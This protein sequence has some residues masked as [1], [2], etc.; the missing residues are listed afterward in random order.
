MKNL[1]SIDLLSAFDSIN[2]SIAIL[3]P[4]FEKSQEIKDFEFLYINPV[5]ESL[6]GK[7]KEDILGKKVIEIFPGVKQDGILDRYCRVYQS[8]ES[9]S[10]EFHYKHEYFDNYYLQT[11]KRAGKYLLIQT[12]DISLK[13]QKEISLLE[14][15]EILRKPLSLSKT[16]YFF[17]TTSGHFWSEEMKSIFGLNKISDF[18]EFLNT[19]ENS[20]G[21]KLTEKIRANEGHH[22]FE[23]RFKSKENSKWIYCECRTEFASDCAL[24]KIEG[25]VQDI[26]NRKNLEEELGEKNKLIEKITTVYPDVIFIADLETLKPVY[27]NKSIFASLG[28]NQK[29]IVAGIELNRVLH[30][31]DFKR[32]EEFKNRISN[33]KEDEIYEDVIRF[34]DKLGNTRHFTSRCSALTRFP[35]G[36]IRQFLGTLSDVTEQ[37]KVKESL[38][39][40]NKMLMD[41]Q[42]V[43]NIG[44]WYFKTSTGEC[45]LSDQM[46]HIFGEKIRPVENFYDFLKRRIFSEDFEKLKWLMED[47]I[48][49]NGS[50]Q[51]TYRLIR[52]DGELRIV[53]IKAQAVTDKNDDYYIK[54]VCQDVTEKWFAEEKLRKNEELLA[55][56]EE[57]ASMGS[58]EWDIKLNTVIWTKN[59]YKLLG[60][61]PNSVFVEYETYLK[62]LHPE[63][64]EQTDEIIKNTLAGKD[65]FSIE[66]RII[67]KDGKIRVFLVSGRVFRNASGDPLKMTVTCIDVTQKRKIEKAAREKEIAIEA[68]KLLSQKKNEFISIASHE[69]KTP[70]TSLKA[71]LQLLDRLITD[72]RETE[73]NYIQKT[74]NYIQKLENLIG[75]LLDISKIESGRI[76]FNIEKIELA[77]LLQECIENLKPIHQK[78]NIIF[79]NL[80]VSVQ[81]KGDKQRLEQVMNNLISNAAKYSPKADKLEVNAEIIGNEIIVRVKDYGIGI[82]KELSEKVF[83]RFFRADDVNSSIKG[84]GIGLYISSEIIK[85]HN[86]K[87]GYR[88]DYG[89][90]SE[91]YFSLPLVQ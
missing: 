27:R 17:W 3:G 5:A 85:Q 79:N 35:D 28:Y 34:Q 39:E 83:Q 74:H 40:T 68:E 20:E 49:N 11:V 88:S 65:S 25:F 67:R 37:E 38:K 24:A 10:D 22:I 18:F 14:Q 30:P 56:A 4:V 58:W 29:E 9:E 42:A 57:K 90:G 44:H 75:D 51:A 21:E 82:K 59:L 36:R 69:L 46:F 91:F 41:A 77:G 8:G 12:E 48:K 52:G 47:A 76:L 78:H 16:G 63:E 87:I 53:N 60:Y 70:L 50:C 31:E 15:N 19:G 89:K 73:K 86:G 43:A 61:E 84:L 72:E 32:L 33:L 66:R 81:V 71:Y 23:Y 64:I 54:G 62:H 55:E 45:H 80:P 1:N 13:K 7:S 26:S 6:L 2:Q